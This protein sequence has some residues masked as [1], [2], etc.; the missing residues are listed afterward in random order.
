MLKSIAALVG[1]A[2]VMTLLAGCQMSHP[3]RGPRVRATPELPPNY[4]AP[5][6]AFAPADFNTLGS[7]FLDEY[8][9]QY[10][11]FEGRYMM[12]YQG[13]I[14]AYESIA[15]VMSATFS[16]PDAENP[17]ARMVSIVW[18]IE[19]RELGRPLLNLG[20]G[21]LVSIHGY[22]LPANRQA[23]IKSRKDRILS[24]F[25]RPVILLIRAEPFSD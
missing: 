24:G 20:H 13:A 15:D 21:A 3:S 19:D 9:G 23:Q 22:V 8:V 2:T 17:S 11:V 25:D 18:S 4:Y 6:E 10:I 1:I 12:H 14:V 7:E 5:D 16:P